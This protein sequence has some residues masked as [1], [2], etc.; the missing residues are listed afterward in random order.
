M[1]SL[2]SPLKLE[3]LAKWADVFIVNTPFRAQEIEARI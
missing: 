2:A 1:S 3:R